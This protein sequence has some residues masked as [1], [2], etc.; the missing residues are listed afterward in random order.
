M[1]AVIVIGGIFSHR[2]QQERQRTLGLVA[3][4]LGWQFDLT[5]N[6]EQQNEFDQF[7]MFTTGQSRYA[8][9]RWHFLAGSDGRLPLQD[10]LGHGQKPP[11]DDAPVQLSDRQN[12]VRVGS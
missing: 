12:A 11:D 10:N 6:Y 1:M 3:T 7:G 8:Y 4:E 2:R 9:N 5:K